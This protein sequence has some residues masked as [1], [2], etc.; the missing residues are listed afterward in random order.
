MANEGSQ[1]AHEAIL[2]HALW[3]KMAY[4]KRIVCL[5]N[6]RKTGGTCVAGKEVQTNGYGGWIRPVSARPTAEVR[7]SES[8]YENNSSPKLLDIIDVPLLNP[9]P[10][11][12]QT[13]NHVIDTA[14]RW[15]KIGELPWNALA[16]LRDQ[17]ATLWINSDCT[18]TGAFN[19]ISQA[20][21]ATQHDSLALITP[22]N[23]VVEVGSST[24]NGKTKRTYRGKFDYNGIHYSLSV[25]DTVACNAFAT[26]D[27]GDYPLN[28]V[29]LCVSLTE[30][31]V[32]DGRCHK[33][34]AAIVSNRPL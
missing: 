15:A 23:F 2:R 6:S 19:C 28:D 22:D 26:K 16:H 13:E 9:A 1:L 25:T 8:R 18:N 20:E 33:L 14:Q 17:P 11:H 10:Q 3:D 29:Y 30:P 21:A 31:Y 24:W 5:A 12:H 4:V 34:I 7:T 32:E 27:E